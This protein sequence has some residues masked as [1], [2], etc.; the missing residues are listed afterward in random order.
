MASAEVSAA[1]ASQSAARASPAMAFCVS[2]G[3]TDPQPSRDP[4]HTGFLQKW[5]SSRPTGHRKYRVAVLASRE[6]PYHH[7]NLRQALLDE[8]FAVVRTRG[9]EGLSVRELAR[10][11]GVSTAAPFRHFKSRQALI[12][13]MAEIAAADLRATFMAALQ[14]AAGLPPLER[15]AALGRSYVQW[16]AREP[17]FF[18]VINDPAAVG[19]VPVLLED[20]KATYGVMADLLAPVYGDDPKRLALTLVG[21]RALVYGLAR[22]ASDKNLRLWVP[23]SEFLALQ[24]SVINLFTRHM[25]ESAGII[26]SEPEGAPPSLHP[27]ERAKAS[28]PA[29]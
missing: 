2:P 27:P 3:L 5:L 16:A 26:W 11:A 8:A 17:V 1:L 23:E 18:R 12:N 29:T 22:L 9:L 7:N 20:H 21:A 28:P 25:A 13:A 15:F 19:E 24:E 4:H 14:K 10:N 6:T